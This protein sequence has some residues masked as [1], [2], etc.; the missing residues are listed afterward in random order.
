[1]ASNCKNLL[2]NNFFI[3]SI[4]L[5]SLFQLYF[6]YS[7]ISTPRNYNTSKK[8]DRNSVYRFKMKNMQYYLNLNKTQEN[9]ED[10]PLMNIKILKNLT[11]EGF[12]KINEKREEKLDQRIYMLFY[13]LFHDFVYIII[14]YKFIFGGYKA[15]IIKLLFQIFRFY[16]NC[17]RI[18][19]S[20]PDICP[21]QIVINYFTNLSIR[22]NDMFNT[23]GFEIFEYLCNYVI[24][25]DFIWLCILIKRKRAKN[26]ENMSELNQVK[27]KEEPNVIRIMKD[28]SKEQEKE[29]LKENNIS[30]DNIIKEIQVGKIN[31]DNE[32]EEESENITEDEIKE[33][34]TK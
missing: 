17:K 1:M 16:F 7:T 12:R 27:E 19:K 20:N 8:D 2:L 33:Q 6:H 31:L 22:E 3:L 29:G 32:Q 5:I 14:I 9:F 26:K 4:L 24:I 11:L 15:G 21:F 13:L 28:S 23:E 10:S 34:E 18:K 30:E 25:L